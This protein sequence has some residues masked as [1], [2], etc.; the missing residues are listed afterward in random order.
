MVLPFLDGNGKILVGG[1]NNLTNDPSNSFNAIF[2][3]SGN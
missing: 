2:H 3:I 1:I